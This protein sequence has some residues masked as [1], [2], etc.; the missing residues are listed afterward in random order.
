MNKDNVKFLVN[1]QK[2]SLPEAIA[3]DQELSSE[4]GSG[5]SN[6]FSK[7]VS[8]GYGSIGRTML[9][10]IGTKGNVFS[11]RD[12]VKAAKEAGS[13]NSDNMAGTFLGKQVKQGKIERECQGHYKTIR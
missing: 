8:N 2:M 1:V 12:V 7:P 4:R 9:A 3:F 5:S 10:V 6:E 11:T 13:T